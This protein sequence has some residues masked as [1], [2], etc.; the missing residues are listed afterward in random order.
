MVLFD[1]NVPV[2]AFCQ[3]FERQPEYLA[4]LE[5]LINGNVP[6][7]AC[8]QVLGSFIRIVTQPRIV[9]RTD[10]LEVALAFA[11]TI[12]NS[13][14]CVILAPGPRHWSIFCD[15]CRKVEAKGNIVADAWLA[16]LAI[17][18]GSE[19]IT[20]DRDYARFPGLRWRHPL[21]RKPE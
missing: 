20:T 13:D 3:Q 12:R 4:W 9:T 2:Y 15:L 6:F 11:S 18:T 19:W 5:T 8:D 21:Q 7:G 16:A 1:V 14:N 10:A 17:E